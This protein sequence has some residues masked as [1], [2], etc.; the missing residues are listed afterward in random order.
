MKGETKI[1]QISELAKALDNLTHEERGEVLAILVENNEDI[2]YVS[3]T[4]YITG[5][6]Y[7]TICYNKEPSSV[8]KRNK[9][10]KSDLLDIIV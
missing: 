8:F 1:I 10:V 4:R 9:Q 3:T 2:D 6:Y 7:L 5:V